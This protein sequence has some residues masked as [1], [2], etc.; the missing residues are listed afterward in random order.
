MDSS[1]RLVA[2]QKA[3]APRYSPEKWSVYNLVLN[4]M[5]R[6]TNTVEGWHSKFQNIINCHHPSIWKFIEH[7]Q[8][9]Q[10]ENEV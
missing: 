5:Q 10:R 6:T 9:D 3:L 2:S 7:V 8:K 1:A 4:K